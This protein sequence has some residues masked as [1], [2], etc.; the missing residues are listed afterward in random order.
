MIVSSD[1]LRL[2]KEQETGGELV[3]DL[4]QVIIWLCL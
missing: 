4:F 3:A 1:W 2:S